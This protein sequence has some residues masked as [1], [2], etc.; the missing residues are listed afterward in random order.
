MTKKDE[1]FLPGLGLA[2]T[3]PFG[4]HR[5]Y[6]AVRPDGPAADAA[7]RI[8]GRLRP[9]TTG[10]ITCENLHVSLNLVF[11]G[12]VVPPGLEVAACARVQEIGVGPFVLTFDKVESFPSKRRWCVV[13]TC[14]RGIAA[15]Y[16]LQRKLIHRFSGQEKMGSFMPHMT[17]MYASRFIEKQPVAPISWTVRE[18]L[19]L[20]S[21]YGTG[22]QAVVMRQALR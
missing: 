7:M 21:H 8:S 22:R 2:Q 13:L 19:L 12:D 6:F 1:P 10:V 5:L 11:R 14:S 18:F 17:L 3:T 4:I 16:E 9:A 20:R 15:L